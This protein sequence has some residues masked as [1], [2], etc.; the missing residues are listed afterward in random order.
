LTI[1]PNTGFNATGLP[2]GPFAPASQVYSLTN[3]GGSS[4]KWSLGNTS[5]WLVASITNGTLA[6]GK[7]TNVTISVSANADTLGGGTYPATVTFTNISSNYVESLQFTLDV[8]ESLIVAPAAGFNVSG[9]EGGPFTATSE[10]FTLTN[11]GAVSLNWQA[12]GPVWLNLSPSNGTLGVNSAT[13]VTAI[14]N[15]GANS[16]GPGAYTG[17]VAFTDNNSG[18]VQNRPF[19]LSIGQNIV[20]NGGFETGDFTDWTLNTNG[21]QGDTIV[22]NGGTGIS[23]HAGN[24]YAAFGKMGLSAIFLRHCRQSPASLIC[25]LCG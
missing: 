19:I 11:S 3:I 17:Q 23:P 22:D 12:A 25:S 16:L 6:A 1:T 20:L 7:G 10:D 18:I 14:L 8:T 5:S 15:P 24:Y 13:P 4:F 21:V 2:G 9:A